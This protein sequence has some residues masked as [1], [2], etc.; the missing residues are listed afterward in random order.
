MIDT[1]LNLNDLIKE[2]K[3]LVYSICSKYYHYADKEDLYQA[4]ML[5]LINAYNNFDKEKNVKFST[6]AFP[7]IVG[8]VSKVARE[9]KS[10]KISKDIIRLGRKINE[11]I[12]KHKSVRG[13]EPSIK[14]ISLMLGISEEKI[15]Y[16]NEASNKI[17]S[18]YEVINDDGKELTL[19]DITSDNKNTISNEDMLDLKDAFKYLSLDEKKLLID[20]Y[21]NNL[22]QSEVAKLMGVN[23]VYVSRL[24]KKVL[25]KMKN[26]MI[27]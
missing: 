14:D 27:N 5:G 2:N 18:L 3:S 16:A 11:Y 7:Y 15:I 20:R 9:N 19:L 13:Y 1:Y 4:G 24:E 17:R 22:T 23:Q 25:T 21:Y 12:E 10:I 8:E 6:Y 26:K